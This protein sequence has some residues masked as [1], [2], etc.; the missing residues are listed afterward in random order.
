MGEEDPEERRSLHRGGQQNFTIHGIATFVSRP[1]AVEE[2]REPMY[3][4]LAKSLASQPGVLCSLARLQGT[5]LAG[6]RRTLNI[7]QTNKLH[8]EEQKNTYM[9][10]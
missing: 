3:C 4:K 10:E 9:N 6:A 1:A 8:S 2:R 5:C 7:K